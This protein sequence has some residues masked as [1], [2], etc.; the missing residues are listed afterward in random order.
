M[1]FDYEANT[2]EAETLEAKTSEG[3]VMI[4]QQKPKLDSMIEPDIMAKIE[5]MFEKR[6]DSYYCTNCG[7]KT[8][9]LGHMR[10]HIERHIEG[11]EYPCSTCNRILRSSHTFRE[12]KKICLTNLNKIDV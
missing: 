10:E 6:V 11:L 4:S 3:T 5:S 1:K 12:H 8:K 2:F 9:N 7:Y